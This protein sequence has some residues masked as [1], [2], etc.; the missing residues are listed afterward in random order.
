MSL[1]VSVCP[2][3]TI[4]VCGYEGDDGRNY[5]S[6]YERL[7][8]K[9]ASGHPEGRPVGRAIAGHINHGQVRKLDPG[10]L[11]T[12]QPCGPAPSRI[13]VTSADTRDGETCPWE[14]TLRPTPQFSLSRK[15]LVALVIASPKPRLVGRFSRWADPCLDRPTFF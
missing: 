15:I 10:L 13:S 7:L 2:G 8:N 14:D 9:N 12:D 3:G 5:L 6:P 1:R 11:A 4:G